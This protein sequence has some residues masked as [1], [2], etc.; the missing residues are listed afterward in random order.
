M[1]FQCATFNIENSPKRT[2]FSSVRRK[3]LSDSL[4]MSR[5]ASRSMFLTHL[6]ACKGGKVVTLGLSGHCFPCLSKPP[7]D[8]VACVTISRL[9]KVA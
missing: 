2:P 3:S 9:I 8:W 5:P 1:V 4:M 6:L 7:P